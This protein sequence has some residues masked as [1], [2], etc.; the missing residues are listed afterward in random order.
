MSDQ[1]KKAV[2]LIQAQ[3]LKSQT[4]TDYLEAALDATLRDDFAAAEM[5]L[6]LVSKA[7]E[8]RSAIAAVSGGT[9]N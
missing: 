8:D 4:Q 5:Y 9:A 2:E 3:L 1:K 7:D 6:E